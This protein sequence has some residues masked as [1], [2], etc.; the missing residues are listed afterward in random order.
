[1]KCQPG[2]I[3]CL[4]VLQISTFIYM[5]NREYHISTY[6]KMSVH[7]PSGNFNKDF[8][9]NL[10]FSGKKL[11]GLLPFFRHFFFFGCNLAPKSPKKEA[12]IPTLS[13]AIEISSL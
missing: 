12:L 7:P 13:M 2:D 9:F 3:K 4:V 5:L 8:F 10:K 1:M 6:Y 11:H